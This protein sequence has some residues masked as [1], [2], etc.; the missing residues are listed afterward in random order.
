MITETDEV[1]RA[2]DEAAMH[3][4]EDGATRTRLLLRLVEEGY[5]AL[6]EERHQHAEHRRAAIARTAGMLTGV[7]ESDYLARLRDEWPE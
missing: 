2:L 6:R 4:P 1:A 3:W 7:Y 5:R